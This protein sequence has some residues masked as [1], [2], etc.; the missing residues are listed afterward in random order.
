MT[1]DMYLCHCEVVQRFTMRQVQLRA[2]ITPKIR[3]IDPISN[4]F[5]LFRF[6]WDSGSYRQM[7]KHFFINLNVYMMIYSYIL[8]NIPLFCLSFLCFYSR[9]F[10]II[11]CWGG[12]LKIN[13]KEFKPVVFSNVLLI[14]IF[15]VPTQG[16]AYG[17]FMIPQGNSTK[18]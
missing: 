11:V 2:K 3:T 8:Q 18:N 1:F 6:I 16:T 15:N 10:F 4:S 13:R 17:S 5:R 14:F 9:F 7:R 12:W